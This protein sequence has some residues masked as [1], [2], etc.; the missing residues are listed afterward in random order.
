[1]SFTHC[2]NP[3]D[4]PV[5]LPAGCTVGVYWII[6]GVNVKEE[7]QTIRETLPDSAPQSPLIPHVLEMYEAIVKVCENPRQQRLLACCCT[8]LHR[9]I[10]P[11][12]M[13]SDRPHC[14]NT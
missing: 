1:M 8:V 9:C 6:D 7:C 14:L 10:V 5:Q 2:L 12:T 3:P 4:K 11:E 13:T